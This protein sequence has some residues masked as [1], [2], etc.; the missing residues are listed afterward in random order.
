MHEVSEPHE[1]PAIVLKCSG[2]SLEIISANYFAL[3]S[4][5]PRMFSMGFRIRIDSNFGNVS[6]LRHFTVRREVGLERLPL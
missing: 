5:N 2:C 6:E 3:S 4:T 1:L